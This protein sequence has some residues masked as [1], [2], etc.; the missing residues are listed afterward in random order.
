MRILKAIVDFY[1]Q[2][3]LH[4]ALAI[5]SL[6]R[7]TEI[8]L[9]ITPHFPISNVVFF[10]TIVG[11]NFLK[12]FESFQKENFDFDKNRYIIG[13]SFFSIIA[14][15]FFFIQLN[16]TTQIFF[17]KIVLIV[18]FYP[19]LRKYGFLKLFLVSFCVSVITV[20]VP[21][22]Q[23]NTFS[24]DAK[25]IL[26]QRFLIV[27]SLM[28]PFEIL[29]SQTDDKKLGTLPQ[30]FGIL[31]TKWFGVFLLLP[32][33]ILEFLKDKMEIS[34]FLITIITALFIVFTDLKRDKYY[35]SFWVESVPILWLILIS[36]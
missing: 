15:I 18:L 22:I 32:F 25:I 9:Q 10:G 21:V 20:N 19:F 23:L 2:A 13:V 6:V 8:A 36:F 12:Y 14:T 11:Y 33:I 16:N 26:L 31:K 17:I 1:I 34:T 5:Y 7:I 4:V 29:D 24:D 30:R 28:I 35:T 3:S 27:I